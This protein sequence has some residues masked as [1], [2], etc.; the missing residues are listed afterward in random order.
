MFD[1]LFQLPHGVVV[2]DEFEGGDHHLSLLPE[3]S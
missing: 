3:G 2:A 1:L